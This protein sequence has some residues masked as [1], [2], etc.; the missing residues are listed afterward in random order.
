MHEVRSIAGAISPKSVVASQTGLVFAQNMM[1]THTVTVYDREGELVA[2]IPD[3]VRL[4]ELGS[5]N[6]EGRFRGAPVEAAFTP[7]GRAAYVSNYAMYGPGFD[8]QGQDTCAP[9]NHYDDSFVYRI[10]TATLQIDQAIAVGS[11]PKYVAV[12]PDGRW[13]LVANWC[14]YDLSVI[15]TV[16]GDEVRRIELGRYP[17]GIAVSPDSS[18]AYVAL[19]GEGRIAVV[20]LETFR[21]GWIKGI[22]NGPRHLVTDPNGRYLYAT[23]NA[24]GTVAK[25]DLASGR[26]VDRVATGAEPRSM[27]MAPDGGSLYVVNYG[28]DTMSKV[29]TKHPRVVQTVSPCYHPIGVTYENATRTVWVACYGG[30]IQ[31]FE[32]R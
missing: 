17:R 27:A 28:S 2:T 30:S 7:D 8:R 12:T 32:E 25:V 10:D 26:I 3:A 4:S 29:T 23:L 19:M 6:R 5:R 31:R 18:T 24:D 13:V 15:D 14:S 20:D 9:A 22:G 11:V 1:Y 21:V 16:A